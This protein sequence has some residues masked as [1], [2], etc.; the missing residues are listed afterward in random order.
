MTISTGST[1]V[2]DK[3]DGAA[4]ADGTSSFL[5]QIFQRSSTVI[6]TAPTGG[7]YNFSTNT[8][9]PP[10]G[11]SNTVP[12]GT[13]PLYTSS[14]TASIQG[15]TGTDSSLTWS[16]PVVLAQNGTNGTIGADGERGPVIGFYASMSTADYNSGS[17]TQA[18]MNLAFQTKTGHS[19]PVENDYG[20]FYDIANPGSNKITRAFIGG[21]WQSAGE[22]IDG[23]L[24][25]TGSI[26]GSKLV[27]NTVDG[28]RINA[29]S[30]VSV[31]ST[32]TEGAALDGRTATAQGLSKA[33]RI[34]AGSQTASDNTNIKFSVDEDGAVL[35][36]DHTGSGERI[37][38]T[39]SRIKVYD[40]SNNVRVLIG[41]L[42]P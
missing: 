25:V 3:I 8:G 42:T 32:S 23:N 33:R 4:G 37:E 34:Y 20:T 38:I 9:T 1:Y 30:Q 13:D 10:S 11:W 41:D 7:S 27:V 40:S 12:S 6:G 31:G 15:T 21:S 28:D 39:D 22:E 36:G 5:Y 14:T 24:F 16:A 26:V 29:L 18:A 19:G 2:F 17:P 35:I